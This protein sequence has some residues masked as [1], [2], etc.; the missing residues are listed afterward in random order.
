MK[1]MTRHIQH[2]LP[3]I[4]ILL[5]GFLGFWIFSYDQ[6]FQMAI[7]LGLSASYVSWGIIH[8]YIHKDLHAS[9]VVEYLAVALLGLVVVYSLIIRA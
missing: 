9:V 6:V 3:L 1:Y 2:Y 8:H 7:A 4:G 5:A